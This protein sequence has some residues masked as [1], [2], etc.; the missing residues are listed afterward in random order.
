VIIVDG[1]NMLFVEERIRRRSIRGD[2]RE[3]RA[4]LADG[5]REYAE[6][7]RQ[8]V[9]LTFDGVARPGEPAG[10]VSPYMQII[11]S[12]PITADHL[13]V[14]MLRQ[15]LD[16]AGVAVVSSDREV[17]H[18]CRGMGAQIVT[19]GRFSRM[20]RDREPIFDPLDPASPDS[21]DRRFRTLTRRSP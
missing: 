9:T 2:Y 15:G 6:H 21:L 18:V 17:K 4:L 16:P 8:P 3:A 14:D 11:F 19:S 20:V 5:I 1:N 7:T 12:G 13:I 10:R